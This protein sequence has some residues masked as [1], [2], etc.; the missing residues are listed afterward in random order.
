MFDLAGTVLTHVYCSMFKCKQQLNAKSNNCLKNKLYVC[1]CVC[2]VCIYMCV[3]LC[4]RIICVIYMSVFLVCVCL[5]VCVNMSVCV[6]ESVCPLPALLSLSRV[7]CVFWGSARRII[8]P[9]HSDRRVDRPAVTGPDTH[10][11][12]NA[13]AEVRGRREGQG[14]ESLASQVLG[15]VFLYHAG[16]VHGAVSL[17]Y[18]TLFVDKE[19]GKI[20]F[21]VIS[22]HALSIGLALHPFPQGVGVVSVDVNLTEHIKLHV[23]TFGKFLDLLVC[24][25]FLVSELVTGES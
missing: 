14:E 20:P 2:V 9:V 8:G 24:T 3:C 19:L 13:T 21:D 1:V 22:Q 18:L 25:R 7:R 12:Q 15:K 23:V 16:V 11:T 6:Y 4:L 5:C 17:H 10:T